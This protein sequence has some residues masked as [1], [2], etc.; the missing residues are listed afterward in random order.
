[1]F[2]EIR[3][4]VMKS[5]DG[6]G[7]YY[8]HDL[9]G[10]EVFHL[11]NKSTELCGAFTFATPS[12]DSKGVA[13]ILEHTVLCGSGRYP[14]KDPFSQLINS[15]PNTFLN[16]MTF[17]DKTMYPFASPLKKDFDILFNVY[18]DA[19]FNPLLRKESF[20][21]EGVRF[22]DKGVD[23]VVFNEMRGADNSEESIVSNAVNEAV[24]GGTPASFNSGGDPLCIADLTYEE[25]LAR[26]RKWY[27]PANCRLFLY[28]DLDAA[29]YMEE[30]EKLYL[31]EEN[32]KRW[33]NE[34]IIPS[35]E[36]YKL[37]FNSPIRK[38]ALCPS[39]T[40]SG[41]LVTWVTGP[42]DDPFAVLALSILTDIL[43]G[44][45]GAP[46]YREIVQSG[47]GEDLNPLSGLD[48]YSPLLTFSAGFTGADKEKTG[49]IESFIVKTLH[50]I[51]S[52][53]IDPVEVEAAMRRQEFRL[54]EIQG[55]GLPYGINLA[56]KCANYWTRGLA[57]EP[58]LDDAALFERLKAEVAN[59]RYF[60]NLIEKLL[61]TN[62][63]RCYTT[64]SYDPDF[65]KNLQARL[66]E[67]FASFR[68]AA[69]S[70]A[71]EKDRTD[72]ENFINSEDSPEALASIE[73]IGRDDLPEQIRPFAME[74]DKSGDFEIRKACL[75]TNSV[76][77]AD[78]A[79][80]TDGLTER[81]W[82]IL[83][84]LIRML[85]MCGTSDMDYTELAKQMRMVTGDFYVSHTCALLPDG[86]TASYVTV[87]AKALRR[88]FPRAAELVMHLLSD[89]DLR[90]VSRIKDSLTDLITGI[91][92]NY[93]Y[94][95]NSFA[96]MY[97]ASS[98]SEPMLITD[99]VSGTRS[100]L[101]MKSLK[102]LDSKGLE[103]L[104]NELSELAAQIFR[105]SSMIMGLGCSEDMMAECVNIVRE[106]S[107]SLKEG[108][109]VRSPDLVPDGVNGNSKFDLL[110]LS[111][112]PAF[113]SRVF[114]LSGETEEDLVADMLF[115]SVTGNTW[116]W[117]EIRA[118]GGAY[119]A[120]SHVHMND[121]LYVL[122]TYR[123][124]SVSSTYKV[125]EDISGCSI[126]AAELDSTVV[127][128][129][130]RELKPLAP[131]SYCSEA[132]R[133]SLFLMTDQRYLERR[134]ILL[135]LTVEDLQRAGRRLG[136]LMAQ[137]HADASV[138]GA[139]LADEIPQSSGAFRLELPL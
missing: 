126:S 69:D 110:I 22:F 9:T 20:E 115:A 4:T 114:D 121:R 53:G 68:K 12:E 73:K 135:S 71:L 61:V 107:C 43:L 11:K 128:V 49:A 117:N 90:D 55:A 132:F 23:G 37:N 84:L 54:M 56:M 16:A 62:P 129:I 1:M 123:D 97:A 106:K 60:E 25:Y 29:Q 26:Y 76:V 138:C 51:A 80:P 6:E 67:K 18:A 101:N 21:Q 17:T 112:G 3:R 98:M 46:L 88:W 86:R 125:F 27:S 14:V 65:E 39:K 35:P 13:H 139:R 36:K 82:K 63:C 40:A 44:N 87:R 134:K 94:S 127:T 102:K 113:N 28:G 118:K 2:N 59:G 91:E 48:Y 119:G 42:A 10:M 74:C 50:N 104:G 103:K 96:S 34:K 33:N 75:F 78:M 133:R 81:Q 83:P 108:K 57:P 131:S 105:R 15:S 136:K 47:L 124:P 95:A 92:Q 70:V 89:A 24:F 19:V 45:P 38:T 72:F 93:Q 31:G 66:D 109:L 120:E 100:W 30:L 58:G 122:S 7:I 52:E 41:A 130:G 99:T 137:K 32:L 111:S 116:L 8:V 64:S 79:F 85:H 77:Y 5:Y